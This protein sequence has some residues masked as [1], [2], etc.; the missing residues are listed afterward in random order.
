M[1]RKA[2]GRMLSPTVS[3]SER[4]S[5][6]SLKAALLYT[7]IIPHCDDWGRMSAVPGTV[8]GTVVPM[9]HD[10]RTRDIPDLLSEIEHAGLI[11]RYM[12]PSKPDLGPNVLQVLDWQ[13]Y[14]I[15]NSP[16]PSRFPPPP[17]R[18]PDRIKP[19]QRRDSL[20]RFESGRFGSF[21]STVP[22]NGP[23]YEIENEYEEE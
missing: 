18:P 6:L 22:H 8:K 9:R 19:P 7:W 20:G 4:V 14:Q 12:N 11:E 2:R 16:R 23:E 15:L 21:P 3:V 10:I 5:R 17:G 13:D 1:A